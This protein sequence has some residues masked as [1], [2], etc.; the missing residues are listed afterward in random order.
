MPFFNRKDHRRLICRKNN[1]SMKTVAI[2]TCFC[3][4][5]FNQEYLAN[6]C[7]SKNTKRKFDGEQHFIICFFPSKEH[8][9][10]SVDTSSKIIVKNLVNFPTRVL[11]QTATAYVF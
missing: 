1:D 7:A 10:I 2:K 3:F 8:S 6:N 9:K 11:L 4:L 5:S